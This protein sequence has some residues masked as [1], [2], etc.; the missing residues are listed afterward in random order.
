MQTIARA[1]RVYDDEKENG[2]IVDYGNV[3][4]NLERAYAIYGE[5]GT[6]KPKGS[7]EV[8][9]PMEPQ[10]AEELDAAVESVKAFLGAIGFDI[11]SLVSC[12]SPIEK[13]GLINNAMNAIC[14]NETTRTQ[15]EFLARDVFR[16]FNALY[17]EE[18]VKP[19]LKLK[20]AIEAVYDRLNQKVKAAD[21][22]SVILRLQQE[23]N[24]SVLVDTSKPVSDDSYVDLSQLDFDKLR[25]AFDNHP[26]PNVL[27]YDLQEAIE[28]R[29]E[30]MI[31]RNPL[32]L[33]FYQKYKDIIEAYNQGKDLQSVREA[34]DKLNEFI[35]ELS[36]E[37][38]RAIKEGLD[39]ETLAIFDL[40]KKP[41]LSNKE[42][43][44]VK[45]VAKETLT[46]LK[47]EKLKIANWRASIQIAA[48]VKTAIFDRLQWLP[49]EAYSD[50]E[51]EFKTS[52]VYQHV[53]AN[54]SNT[55]FN[56]Y[57]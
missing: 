13:L 28:N 32:R 18:S 29:L 23:V 1:N 2:L 6:K 31:Q 20:N 39:E 26:Q 50:D 45:K 55:G 56:A 44:A 40:L 11:E 14:L 47:A 54:Y 30:K 48:Q 41:N 53:Y 33:E 10:T 52:Q 57:A 46:I 4:K 34:F 8:D 49:Q 51:V 5:G 9:A 27:V 38:S 37:E 24:M 43:D 12:N 22:T 17:P 15:F 36:S 7:D 35:S 16:K 19:Y 25:A 42:I 21:I 3:Y